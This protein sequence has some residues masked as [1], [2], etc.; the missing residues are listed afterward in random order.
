LPGDIVERVLEKLRAEILSGTTTPIP[1]AELPTAKVELPA[2]PGKISQ[3]PADD[4]I[5]HRKLDDL[6]KPRS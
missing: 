3:P 6:T 2:A 5:D 4:A 1:Q